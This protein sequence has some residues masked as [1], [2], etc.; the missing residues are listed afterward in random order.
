MINS[1]RGFRRILFS[2]ILISQV[3]LGISL[4]LVFQNNNV[5]SNNTETD[6]LKLSQTNGNFSIETFFPRLVWLEGQLKINISSNQTGQ[7]FCYLNEISANS[8]F[9]E[10]NQTINLIGNNISQEILLKAR[11]N[12]FTFPGTYRFELIITG[13]HNYNENFEITFVLGYS[14]LTII[15]AAFIIGLIIILINHKKVIKSKTFPQVTDGTESLGVSSIIHGKI[16][17]PECHKSIDEG[18]TFCPEC[19]ARIP[20][21]LRYNPPGM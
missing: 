19:G 10:V 4:N 7:I 18:L 15:L 1:N 12:F 2:L 14:V 17:C 5:L 6:Y 11:P 16:R 3:I 13:I 9:Y 8:G 21:F 20:E